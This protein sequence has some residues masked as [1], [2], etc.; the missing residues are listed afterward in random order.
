MMW[1]R[2]LCPFAVW[3]LIEA[4]EAL[5]VNNCLAQVDRAGTSVLCGKNR[6][7]LEVG[8]VRPLFTSDYNF[9]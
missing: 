4:C 1:R 5:T 8:H 9:G 6:E 2:S 7:E 3:V